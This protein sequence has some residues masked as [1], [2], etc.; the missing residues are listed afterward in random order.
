MAIRGRVSPEWYHGRGS[1]VMGRGGGVWVEIKSAPGYSRG[2]GRL[3]LRVRVRV[4][5][6]VGVRVREGGLISTHACL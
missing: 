6:R 4:R 5:F 2:D 1:G 3:R